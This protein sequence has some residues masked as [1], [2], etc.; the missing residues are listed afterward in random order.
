MTVQVRVDY[1]R[2]VTHD[3]ES[4][5]IAGAVEFDILEGEDWQAAYERGFAVFKTIVD[6]K[7][8]EVVGNSGGVLDTAPAMLPPS[9]MPP[10]PP[11]PQPTP[12][13]PPPVQAQ[14]PQPQAVQQ[15]PSTAAAGTPDPSVMVDEQEVYFE[16]VR[17][18]KSFET[19]DYGVVYTQSKKKY[20]KVRVGKDGPQGIP[21]QYIDVSIWEPSAYGLVESGVIQKGTYLNIWGKYKAWRSNASRFDIWATAVQVAT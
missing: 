21:G 14:P 1:G 16:R 10:I 2:T 20:A 12:P 19:P 17:V 4:T 11:P 13:P 18:I 6:A 15:T 5:R 3:Y 8:A 9:P 7:V